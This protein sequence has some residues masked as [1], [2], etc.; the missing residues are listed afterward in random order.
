MDRELYKITIIDSIEGTNQSQIVT[1]YATSVEQ[2]DFLGFIEIKGIEF[3][4]A[5]ELI[6]SPSEDRAHALF[7]DTKRIIIPSSHIVRI[8]ELKEEK[9]ATIISIFKKDVVL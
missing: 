6:L 4:N 1:L 8:E 2:A 9:H 5:S 7:K 3:P